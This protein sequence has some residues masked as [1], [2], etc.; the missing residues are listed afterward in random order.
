VQSRTDPGTVNAVTI[1]DDLL[2]F[3]KN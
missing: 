1:N 2:D 3:I